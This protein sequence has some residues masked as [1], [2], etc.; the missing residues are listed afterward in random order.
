LRITVIGLP[1]SPAVTANTTLCTGGTDTMHFYCVDSMNNYQWQRETDSFWIDIAGA[2]TRLYTADNV[3]MSSAGNYRVR[4]NNGCFD[5]FSESVRVRMDTVPII[6]PDYVQN[7]F[8]YE[9]DSA[10]LAYSFLNSADGGGV[11]YSDWQIRLNGDSIFTAADYI[12][13][14]WIISTPVQLDSAAIYAKISNRCGTG[15]SD[16]F[17][18]YVTE[19]EKIFVDTINMDIPQRNIYDS[20]FIKN[21]LYP[22]SDGHNHYTVEIFDDEWIF[23][24]NPGKKGINTVWKWEMI[25]PDSMHWYDVDTAKIRNDTLITVEH[26][27]E[28]RLVGYTSA[29]AYSDTSVA[30]E[31]KI[32]TKEYIHIDSIEVKRT[33][34][35]EPSEDFPTV[36]FYGDTITVKMCGD[37]RITITVHVSGDYSP[38]TYDWDGNEP[39]SGSPTDSVFVFHA[40]NNTDIWYCRI[41][42]TKGNVRKIT[43]LADYRY[44]SELIVIVNPKMALGKYY[45]GQQ[46]EIDVIS[47]YYGLCRFYQYEN[48]KMVRSDST[49]TP[50]FKTAFNSNYNTVRVN[51][52]DTNGCRVTDVVNIEILP[53]PNVLILNNP[54]YPDAGIIFPN[55]RITVYSSWGVKI[56][57]R[58]DGFG[59][60][61]TDSKGRQVGSGTYFYYVEIKTESGIEIIHGAVTVFKK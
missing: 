34:S 56:K 32:I 42:D 10:Y 28:Y 1:D 59:W 22:A 50:Y 15:T 49:N 2:N 38:F 31:T 45:Q 16:T 44:P 55:F 24:Y 14:N 21:T 53:L 35:D 23:L 46:V 60:D 27:A 30:I 41:S 26:L 9:F 18:I 58:N 5:V 11:I 61:G 3:T 43:V 39:V 57:D 12:N 7:I 36:V 33:I 4:V 19:R 20:A 25:S 40:D 47:Q 54:K 48:D 29:P 37:D 13:M 8:L 17:H 52:I 6:T 51:V